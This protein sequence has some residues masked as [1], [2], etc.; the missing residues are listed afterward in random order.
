MTQLGQTILTSFL[1]GGGL[2]IVLWLLQR[3]AQK[4]D[5]KKGRYAEIK[6]S[7]EH[8][9]KQIEALDHKQDVAEADRWRSEILRF[10]SE[11]HRE[12]AHTTEEYSEALRM[13]DRYVRYCRE[14]PGYEN[15]KAEVAIDDIT[16]K[17]RDREKKRDY[18]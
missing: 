2:S 16:N 1:T 18:V 15:T 11:L 6:Q 12:V 4:H 5:E 7:L 17:Y 9:K 10:D 13:V 14:H 8:L 3:A